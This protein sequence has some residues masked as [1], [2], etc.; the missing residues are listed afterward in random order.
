M[1]QNVL[2]ISAGASLGALLRWILG[3]A[4][5]GV[6]PLMPLGTLLANL[7]GGYCIGVMLGV[8]AFFP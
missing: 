7:A 6:M 5:N 1:L 2:C 3:L 4:F 8:V